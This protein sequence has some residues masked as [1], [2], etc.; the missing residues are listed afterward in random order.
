M[1]GYRA[2]DIWTWIVQLFFTA[3]LPM[4]YCMPPSVTVMSCSDFSDIVPTR[5][6]LYYSI[7]CSTQCTTLRTWL[8]KVRIWTPCCGAASLLC[9][10][11]PGQKFNAALAQ[12]L[13]AK[14]FVKGE[15]NWNVE[16]LFP[17]DSVGFKL[18]FLWMKNLI[19]SLSLRI[20]AATFGAGTASPLRVRNLLQHWINFLFLAN[21]LREQFIDTAEHLFPEYSVN[22]ITHSNCWE[23]V[24]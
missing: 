14:R 16:V 10:S 11:S 17:S 6:Q 23:L 9:G 15:V 13:Q 5:F 24:P 21:L 7:P 18:I 12:T 2:C 8:A 19:K 3:K 4:S 22:T 20:G 1:G